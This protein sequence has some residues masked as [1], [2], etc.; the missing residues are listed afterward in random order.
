MAVAV[1]VPTGT[2]LVM[3]EQA[4]R[5]AASLLRQA[6][7]PL[8]SPATSIRP[9]VAAAVVAIVVHLLMVVPGETPVIF[10]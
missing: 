10:L 8:Q 3:V 6:V 2:P 7:G 1:V 5:E 9:E 4:G